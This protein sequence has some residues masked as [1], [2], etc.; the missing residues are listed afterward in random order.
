[1]ASLFL[2]FPLIISF[3][4]RFSLV[5][6]LVCSLFELDDPAGIAII[7]INYMGRREQV[8]TSQ[9]RQLQGFGVIVMTGELNSILYDT[10]P[11]LKLSCK[12]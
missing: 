7:P 12:H 2:L 9:N 10:W 3:L 4:R 1:M 6:L 5:L 11:L 8:P